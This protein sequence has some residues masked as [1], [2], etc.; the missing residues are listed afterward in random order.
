MKTALI[1]GG[2]S[3]IGLSIASGLLEKGYEVYLIGR[4]AEKG[5]AAER[6]LDAQYPGKARFIPLDLSPVSYTHLT[7]PTTPYV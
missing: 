5:K 4:N 2:T 6:A 3:G 1:S 7:L